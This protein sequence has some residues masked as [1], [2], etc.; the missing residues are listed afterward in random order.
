MWQV[1]EARSHPAES[2][3]GG[4]GQEDVYSLTARHVDECE[5]P[6]FDIEDLS[7]IVARPVLVSAPW[8]V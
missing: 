6:P 3:D 4:V 1:L 5:E 7:R 8:R 2:G